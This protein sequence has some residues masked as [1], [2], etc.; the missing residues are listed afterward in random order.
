MC[1]PNLCKKEPIPKKLPLEMESEVKKLKKIKSKLAV[2]KEAYKFVSGNF[3]KYC[4]I[5]L[6]LLK[7]PRL[8]KKDVSSIWD[9]KYSDD[10]FLH[11][12]QLN[13]LIRVLL[14]KSKKFKEKDIGLVNIFQWP[15]FIHQYLIIKID[16]KFID[17]DV[18]YSKLGIAFGKHE[19]VLLYLGK[20]IF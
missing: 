16:K 12:T 20:P 13:Y 1:I 2:L 6:N 8:Y 9:Y 18:W 17:V 15:P 14:I 3:G 11:C 19:P 7:L 4:K 5:Y 10:P